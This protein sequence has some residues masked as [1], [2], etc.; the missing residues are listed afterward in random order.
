MLVELTPEIAKDSSVLAV[1]LEFAEI[2]LQFTGKSAAE[3]SCRAVGFG[4]AQTG[5]QFGPVE[6]VG[7]I[8]SGTFGRCHRESGQQDQEQGD[9]HDQHPEDLRRERLAEGVLDHGQ[10]GSHDSSPD[11][12]LTSLRNASSRVSFCRVIVAML[13]P[14]VRS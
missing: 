11:A 3:F 7:K 5:G 8:E 6:N 4:V 1:E 13:I 2:V 12:P 10:V 14:A 9:H